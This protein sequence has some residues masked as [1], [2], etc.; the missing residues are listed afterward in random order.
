MNKVKK[1]PYLSNKY[2]H[3]H[4]LKEER[5]LTSLMGFGNLFQ[6]T[7]PMNLNPGRTVPKPK[8][9]GRPLNH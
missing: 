6:R 8:R 4:F 1:Q 5:L 3:N 2:L 7:G 9:E